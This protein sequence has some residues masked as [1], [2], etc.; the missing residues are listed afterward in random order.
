M[1]IEDVLHKVLQHERYTVPDLL[2]FLTL[3]PARV[4]TAP[5]RGVSDVLRLQLRAH[6]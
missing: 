5:R 6:L 1:T 4:R 2:R 3:K